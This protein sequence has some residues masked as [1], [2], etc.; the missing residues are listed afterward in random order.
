M[1]VDFWAKPFFFHYRYSMYKKNDN[2]PLH[3]SN[4]DLA[5]ILYIRDFQKGKK[6]KEYCIIVHLLKR[7]QP[8]GAQEILM[9]SKSALTCMLHLRC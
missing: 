6:E 9:I 7:V 2:P 5:A 8:I 3:H 1:C 4:L